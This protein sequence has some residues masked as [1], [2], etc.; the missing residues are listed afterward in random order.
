MQLQVSNMRKNFII[1]G[2]GKH[3]L[4]VLNEIIS[5]YNADQIFFFNDKEKKIILK[6]EIKNIL[7]LKLFLKLNN[8]IKKT[9]IFSLLLDQ[10]L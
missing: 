5:E 9:H 6:L 7:Y 4:L 2:T 10:I 3:A 8:N 1:F